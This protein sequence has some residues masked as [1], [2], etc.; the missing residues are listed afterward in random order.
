MSSKYENNKLKKND[1]NLLTGGC[2]NIFMNVVI[3]Q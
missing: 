1:N 3:A 2:V